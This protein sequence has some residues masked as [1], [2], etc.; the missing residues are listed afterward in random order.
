MGDGVFNGCTALERVS[1]PRFITNIRYH[2]FYNCSALTGIDIP[3]Y[4]AEIGDRAFYGCT[5]LA[6]VIIPDGVTSIGE[7]AFYTCEGLTSVTVPGGVTSVGEEAFAYCADLEEARF[8][9]NAPDES[10][11]D[12]FAGTASGFKVYYRQGA[13]GFESPMWNG[14]PCEMVPEA[15]FTSIQE[16]TLSFDWTTDTVSGDI[17]V[18]AKNNGSG[19]APSV[20][21]LVIYSGENKV[22][23]LVSDTRPLNAGDNT[24][25]FSDVSFAGA[26]GEIYYYKILTLKNM[27]NIQ[28]LTKPCFKVIST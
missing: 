20:V 5:G 4:V 9:G 22:I 1:L 7:R 24:I 2:M 8:Y 6:S 23:K 27:T 28:P 13:E 25:Y 16:S 26:E 14:Y 11:S 3:E 18:S 10:G 17:V 15:F 12:V 21:L 19:S